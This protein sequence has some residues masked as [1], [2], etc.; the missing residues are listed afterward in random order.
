MKALLCSF[1]IA[2]AAIAGSAVAAAPAAA[3]AGSTGQCKDGSYTSAAGKKGA[4][5]GHKGVQAWY[6]DDASDAK[7]TTAK[8]PA[9]TTTS[10][11]TTS[12]A[13][14]KKADASEATATAPASA[15]A[16]STGLCNDGSYSIAAKKQ[17]ACRGHKG[18]KDWYGVSASSTAPSIPG[19]T[20]TKTPPA[21]P[22]T[23]P[24]PAS[25]MP[26]ATAPNASAPAGAMTSTK[27]AA[28]GGGAGKVWVNS[29][30]KV[31]HCQ[32]D[33]YYGTTKAGEYMSESDA[34]A[35]GNR[36]AKGKSCGS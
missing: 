14:S 9:A 21:K 16:G 25:S 11:A 17:G 6:G 4:C 13:A 34:V 19:L 24:M 8:T 32:G 15:P 5:R 26:A 20:T 18:V 29:A 31:Y 36:A 30:T 10:T 3:P 28:P 27:T 22:A 23:S 33:R 35:K 2:L 7:A 12:S 1:A